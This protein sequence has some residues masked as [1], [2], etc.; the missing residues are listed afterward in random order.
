MLAAPAAETTPAIS[1]SKTEK[2]ADDSTAEAITV[3]E[4]TTLVLR[5]INYSF[6]HN[7]FAFCIVLL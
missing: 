3:T 5:S 1:K 2:E 7:T 4:E 6:C